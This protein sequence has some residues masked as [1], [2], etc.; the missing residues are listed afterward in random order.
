MNHNSPHYPTSPSYDRASPTPSSPSSPAPSHDGSYRSGSKG[1]KTNTA[2][3]LPESL[4]SSTIDFP[5]PK[6]RRKLPSELGSPGPMGTAEYPNAHQHME[7]GSTEEGSEEDEASKQAKEDPL[8]AQVWRLYTKAKDSLPN[9]K[10]LENLTWRM[11]AMTLHKKNKEKE[12]KER[13]G[14]NMDLERPVPA[15]QPSYMDTVSSQPMPP[16]MSITIPGPSH[17]SNPNGGMYD[18]AM[19][20]DSDDDQDTQSNASSTASS[21]REMRFA[22]IPMMTPIKSPPVSQNNNSNFKF[23][24]SSS[25]SPSSRHKKPNSFGSN[26]TT[27]TNSN[28]NFFHNNAVQQNSN[29]FNNNLGNSSNSNSSSFDKS[30]QSFGAKSPTN[31]VMNGVSPSPTNPVSIDFT[32]GAGPS[33][34]ANNSSSSQSS[35]P[36]LSRSS[37]GSKSGHS[38]SSRNSNQR[39]SSYQGKVWIENIT[40][41]RGYG[42]V[43]LHDVNMQT[44]LFFP[45]P[46]AKLEPFPLFFFAACC[47][48]DLLVHTFG[49]V[50]V[51]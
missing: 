22:G 24:S 39:L 1:K 44:H 48:N 26:T 20:S 4:L 16:T 45:S 46:D 13:N 6:P 41:L 14:H 15:G 2:N 47:V 36:T 10:R 37:T 38:T 49:K 11:M 32:G 33:F 35:R 3:R 18:T 8:A 23:S 28:N 7:D 19:Q 27:T 9:G 17:R 40:W 30:S 29:N 31:T 42:F 25:V 12:D 34:S 5:K 50:A 21:P 43:D 51:C